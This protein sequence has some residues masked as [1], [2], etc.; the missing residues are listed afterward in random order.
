MICAELTLLLLGIVYKA[1]FLLTICLFV[2]G[3]AILIISL[4]DVIQNTQMSDLCQK[5][6]QQYAKQDKTYAKQ[7]ATS[8]IH[9]LQST[10]KGK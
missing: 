10:N 5:E 2:K 6:D 1:D 4:I 9:S 8:T 3:V 7:D